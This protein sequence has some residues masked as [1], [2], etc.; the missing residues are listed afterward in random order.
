MNFMF[1]MRSSPDLD[2]LYIIIYLFSLHFRMLNHTFFVFWRFF[3]ALLLD[4]WIKHLLFFVCIHIRGKCLI[5]FKFPFNKMDFIVLKEPTVSGRAR[6]RSPTGHN[7]ANFCP[8]FRKLL[9]GFDQKN[10]FLEC[11]P[12]HFDEPTTF[13]NILFDFNFSHEFQILPSSSS[14]LCRFLQHCCIVQASNQ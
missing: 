1:K 8:I 3:E 5:F 9:K 11:P 7:P 6:T 10:I 14:S 13:R 12:C 4:C 2:S